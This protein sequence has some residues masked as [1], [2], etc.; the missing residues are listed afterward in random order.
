MNMNSSLQPCVGVLATEVFKRNSVA[1][2][3]MHL[4]SERSSC[5]LIVWYRMLVQWL[6]R[7]IG[8]V[9]GQEGSGRT[10]QESWKTFIGTRKPSAG[11]IM[12][13][14]SISPSEWYQ[15]TSRPPGCLTAWRVDCLAGLV[16]GW[17]AGWLAGCLPDWPFVWLAEWLAGQPAGLRVDCLPDWPTVWLAEWL[18]GQPAGLRA[19][20]LPGHLSGWPSV[21]FLGWLIYRLRDWLRDQPTERW[22]TDWMS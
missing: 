13:W 19:D 14:E 11:T 9:S 20:C 8:D 4:L 6:E 17:P 15:L 22:L 12:N 7:E 16:I 2:T 3:R 10:I 1:S 18:A 5:L 21:S